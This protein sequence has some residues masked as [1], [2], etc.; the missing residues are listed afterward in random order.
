MKK[1]FTITIFFA[2]GLCLSAQNLYVQ[3]IDSDQQVA[4]NLANNPE[5]TF[6]NRVMSI[7]MQGSSQNFQLTN[8]QNFSF[9]QRQSTGNVAVTVENSNIRLYPN[10]VQDELTLEIPNPEK[11]TTYRIINLNGAVVE[12]G[13]APSSL[14]KINMQH[15]AS[16]IYVLTVERGG[17]QIQ[18]FRVV[19]Q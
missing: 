17:Q 14:T 18:S 6:A 11:G 16:G 9:A 15:F 4:F 3:P 2:M 10:P 7:E 8:V 13:Q 19:K 1:I 5:I 12:A